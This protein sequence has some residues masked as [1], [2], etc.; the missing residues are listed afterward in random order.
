MSETVLWLVQ[1]IK[2]FVD[3]LNLHKRLDKFAWAVELCEDT[4]ERRRRLSRP[5]SDDRS[6]ASSPEKSCPGRWS[7]TS[8][9]LRMAP[10][11]SDAPL[12]VHVHASLRFRG[13]VTLTLA[14]DL[15]FLRNPAVPTMG[16]GVSQK[17]RAGDFNL[18]S[19]ARFFYLQVEKTS[20]L[21]KGANWLPFRSYLV[22]AD[23]AVN[24]W[25]QHKI[26]ASVARAVI[27]ACKK[28][29]PALLT[30]YER[31]QKEE[32]KEE[33]DSRVSTVRM[34]LQRSLRP[35]R[36]LPQVDAWA[37]TF[38]KVRYRY[39]FL[40][41]DGLSKMGKTLYC[42]SRAPSG[43]ELLEIDCAGADTPDLSSF[44]SGKH[45]MVLC[46]EGSVAMVLRYKKLF[47]ASASFTTLGSSQTNCHSYDVWAHK[48]QFIVTSNR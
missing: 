33:L 12:R 6:E 36:R 20:C 25:Q 40:V 11:E 48:V 38:E 15:A 26:D 4:Y 37:A 39:D 28:N 18:S 32:E 34:E 46:D 27:L 41:L 24:M 8:D 45:T 30:N 42:R 14:K 5:P 3:K 10:A 17:R 47:Q 23:W 7:S 31:V 1:E 43:E 35:C 21:Y 19:N 9:E 29:V 16:T 13:T 22:N 44:E 2:D